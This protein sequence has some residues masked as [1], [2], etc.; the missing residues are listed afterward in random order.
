VENAGRRS[1]TSSF[2]QRLPVA[3]GRK[4][5][6]RSPKAGW[7]GK[8]EKKRAIPREALIASSGKRGPHIDSSRKRKKGRTEWISLQ[9]NPSLEKEG[10]CPGGRGGE[11]GGKKRIS[12]M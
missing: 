12:C 6:H 10:N 3:L 8:R 9:N 2:L 7:D 4:G 5:A 11:R 1:V